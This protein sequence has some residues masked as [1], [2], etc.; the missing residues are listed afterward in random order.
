MMMKIY[1]DTRRTFPSMFIMYSLYY[2]FALQSQ[3]ECNSRQKKNAHLFRLIGWWVCV[4]AI[5][6]S[7]PSATTLVNSCYLIQLCITKFV[8]TTRLKMW[9]DWIN[10]QKCLWHAHCSYTWIREQLRYAHKIGTIVFSF[11]CF[12]FIAHFAAFWCLHWNADRDFKFYSHFEP[13]H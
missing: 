9:H 1:N 7:F 10:V 8:M 12:T 11:V 5:L 13:H 3:R 2:L 6:V 4:V